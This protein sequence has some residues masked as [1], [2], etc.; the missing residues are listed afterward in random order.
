MGWGLEYSAWNI[1]TMQNMLTI[2]LLSILWLFM[3]NYSDRDYN[4]NNNV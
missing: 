4:S 1:V 2:L 3:S